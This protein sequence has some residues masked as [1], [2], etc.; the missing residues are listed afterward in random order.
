MATARPVVKIV[1][2]TEAKNHFGEILKAA[3]LHAEHLIVERDGVPVVAIVPIA[4]YQQ[5]FV[6]DEGGGGE[7]AGEEQRRR[8]ARLSLAQFLQQVHSQLPAV[9]EGEAE[10]DIAEAIRV[11]RARQ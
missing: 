10:A 1:S 5:S 3:Y 4:D 9:P 7:A 6:V 8:Q 2:A 11:T